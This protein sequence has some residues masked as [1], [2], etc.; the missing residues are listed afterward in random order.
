MTTNQADLAQRIEVATSHDRGVRFVCDD[1]AGLVSWAE[2]HDDAR[3]VAR[4]L[5]RRGV[6]PGDR[7]ALVGTTSRRLTTAIQAVWL[8]G[9]AV[10]VPPVPIG[11]PSRRAVETVVDVL[12]VADPSLV[13]A[14]GAWTQTLQQHVTRP[15]EALAAL[16]PR[17]VDAERFDPAPRPVGTIAIVG[18]TSGSVT[19][20]KGVVIGDAQVAA[21]HHACASAVGL[22]DTDRF[23]SWLPLY[24][25]MG[26]AG[27][28][29][30]TMAEG[31]DLVLGS[32]EQFAR[33]PRTWITWTAEHRATM[34]VAPNFAYALAGVALAASNGFDLSAWRLALNGAE[35][36]D[37]GLVRAFLAA[38]APLG[39]RPEV[40]Y[41]CY[42][43]AESTL[44]VTMPDPS[45]GLDVDVVDRRALEHDR[46]AEPAA[47]GGAM[48][49][50]GSPVIGMELRIT[51]PAEGRELK[52]RE[53]GEIQ[54]RGT[55]LMHGYFRRPD[56]TAAA[57]TDDD[58]FR[59]GDLGYLVDGNL[60]VC[61]RIKELIIVGGRN[62]LPHDVERVVMTV[63]GVR[64]AGVVAFGAAANGT[65]GLVVVA[66]TRRAHE[67]ADAVTHRALASSIAT[68][69][70]ERLDVTPREVVLAR[71]GSVPRTTSGKIQRQQARALWEADALDT[72]PRG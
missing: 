26:M 35:P 53:V 72:L 55:S 11:Q 47:D 4:A 21:N 40:A 67:A 36:I 61:G 30:I 65:E 41:P 51:E 34:T 3:G 23:C 31:L 62:L 70:Q 33:S 10:V 68:E 24:H 57:F 1:D 27:V 38:G 14:D 71:R 20:P 5:Q 7:V 60:V 37:V 25:D 58:W 48:A 6:R 45:A 64:A 12:G 63:P 46:V 17:R 13:L 44:A 15:L 9:G 42:G 56:L 49:F 39:L 8:S 69:V 32:P 66:E 16:E 43:M 28:L 52:D 50:V 19:D 29:A 18:F 2:L 59:T 22:D 54:I